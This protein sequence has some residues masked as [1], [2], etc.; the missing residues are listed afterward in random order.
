MEIVMDNSQADL[1]STTFDMQML[2]GTRRRERSLGQWVD[3][4]EQSALQLQEMVS[5]QSFGKILVLTSK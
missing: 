5:L 4:F 1:T 3:L 2:M